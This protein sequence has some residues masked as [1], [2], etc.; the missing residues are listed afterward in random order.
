MLI[1]AGFCVILT[2]YKQYCK[3]QLY[4]TVNKRTV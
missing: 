2:G 1:Q 4:G 3:N